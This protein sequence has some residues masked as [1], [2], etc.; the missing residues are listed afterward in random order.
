MAFTSADIPGQID[1]LLNG[2]GYILAN[3]EVNRAIYGTSPIFVERQNTQGDFGDN[4]QDFWLTASQ[5]DWSLGEDQR[6]F[7]TDEV[8][9]RRFW[10]GTNL[11]P[12]TPGKVLIGSDKKSVT[13]PAA[14]KSAKDWQFQS[15]TASSTN[16]YSVVPGTGGVTDRGAHGG[17]A[18]TNFNMF[19]N[20]SNFFYIYTGTGNI[21]KWS[22]SA[23]SDFAT[24]NQGFPAFLNN[25]LYG[26]SGSVLFRYDTAGAATTLHTF[27]DATGG[28][29]SSSGGFAIP[30]GGD[31][32]LYRSGGAEF[33]NDQLW[34]YDGTGVSLL[35]LLPAN[36]AAG[37]LC[38]SQGVLFIVGSITRTIGSSITT[39]LAY[40]NG[41]LLT[42]WTSTARGNGLQA[43]IAPWNNGVAFLDPGTLRCLYYDLGVGGVYTLFTVS[44]LPGATRMS[45]CTNGIVV[46]QGNTSGYSWP[47]TTPIFATTATLTT[48]LFDFDSSLDKYVKAVK[49]D[50]DAASDGDGGSMDIAYQLNT[51][52]GS[53]TTVQTGAVSGTEYTIGQICRSISI[54]VTMNKSTSSFGPVLKRIYVRAAPVG[55][56]FRRRKYILD[57]SGRNGKSHVELRNGNDHPLDGHQQAVNLNTAIA[58]TTPFTIVDRF[59]SFSGIIE[60]DETQIVEVRPEE[61]V[62]TVV[63]RQV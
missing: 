10:Q 31:L 47:S 60:P 45:S 37:D 52:D 6:Y 11:D 61:Y 19:A 23:F 48:S 17:G 29:G 44:T 5:N 25:S 8:S 2:Q 36:F 20:D 62:A 41:E 27:K 43:S 16:L 32:L 56:Q 30:Y 46:T 21:R 26:F 42:V 1:L 63:V 51:V 53:F 28:T 40:V 59:G 54:K 7:R 14:V 15:L 24:A 39:L 22:G 38:V 50:W 4:Q 18:T 57:L 9:R 12:F 58:L 3:A 13:F 49:I 35:A 34:I 33:A 55:Q